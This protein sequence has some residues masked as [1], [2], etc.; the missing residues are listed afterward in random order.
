MNAFIDRL[1]STAMKNPRNIILPEAQDN[2]VLKAAE[3]L[4]QEKLCNVTLVSDPQA[5]NSSGFNLAG[6]KIVS[7]SDQEL[8]KELAETYYELRKD[9][10]LS[11]VEALR[12]LSKP[13]TLASLLLRQGKVD[14]LVSGS[15][16]PTADVLR[17]GI[18]IVK[19]S[20]GNKTVS[21]FFIMI[22]PSGAFG[23]DGILFFADCG[24]I[25]SPDSE[26]L[27]DIALA[28]AGNFKK[29]IEEDPRVA[30]LSFSTKGS[31]MHA[32][33]EKVKKAFEI[34]SQKNSEAYLMDA[35]LQLD[36]AIVESVAS[37]KAPES[38]VAGK[39]NVL[40]FPDLNAGNIGYKLVQRLANAEAYGPIIQGL[41]KPMNDLSRGCT[42]QD[43]VNVSVITAIQAL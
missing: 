11:W 19:P 15:I 21:S 31:A 7:P 2:R 24:V 33:V 17:A 26:Q 1:K 34:A 23:D 5:I 32:D 41:N 6:A 18:Q 16:S 20:E 22:E 8:V 13:I 4:I 38:A 30:F 39:A 10:G 36:A 3:Y 12:A 28:T 42:W 35:E 43:I 29:L 37:K 27:A 25:P 40:I 14:G 9:K